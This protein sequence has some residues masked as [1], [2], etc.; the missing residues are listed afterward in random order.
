MIG[1]IILVNSAMEETKSYMK[2][3]VETIRYVSVFNFPVKRKKR[4]AT[5]PVNAFICSTMYK[6]K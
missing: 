4:E 6:R 3:Y 2:D 1:C 5:L